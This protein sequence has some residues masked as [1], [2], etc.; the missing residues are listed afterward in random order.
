MTA[1]RE[2]LAAAPPER[3]V[4]ALTAALDL[5]DDPQRHK[6]AL[7]HVDRDDLLAAITAALTPKENDS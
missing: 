2:L 1:A 6:V 5:A 7:G 4:A 3:L